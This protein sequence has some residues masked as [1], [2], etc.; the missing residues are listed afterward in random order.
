MIK[1]L[2][3]MPKWNIIPSSFGYFFTS[4]INNLSNL[5]W[6]IDILLYYDR[7]IPYF[8]Y[9]CFE[10]FKRNEHFH[11]KI[12]KITLLELRLIYFNKW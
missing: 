6:I 9:H 11:D 4:N 2:K 8:K 5:L 12:L 1:I 7:V 10:R 3:I